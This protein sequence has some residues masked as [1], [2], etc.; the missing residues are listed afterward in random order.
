MDDTLKEVHDIVGKTY[1]PG[2]SSERTRFLT[3]PG[4]IVGEPRI[5]DPSST[6]SERHP[7]EAAQEASNQDV[8]A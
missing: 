8:Q 6:T 5:D 7:N 4:G 3:V 2:L 1:D